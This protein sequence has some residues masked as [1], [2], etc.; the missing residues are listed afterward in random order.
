MKFIVF[1]VLLSLTCE[2]NYC[3]Q[4]EE[5][6][7]CFK[8]ASQDELTFN[9][10]NGDKIEKNCLLYVNTIGCLL[11]ITDPIKCSLLNEIAKNNNVQNFGAVYF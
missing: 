3:Q 1:C 9:V 5:E 4:T 10:S 11:A 7:E 2:S 8:S 6:W